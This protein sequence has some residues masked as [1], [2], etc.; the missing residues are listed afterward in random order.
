[1]SKTLF[2]YILK[3]ITQINGN[4]KKNKA[5]VFADAKPGIL[6]KLVTKM[7]RQSYSSGEYIIK[8]GDKA[9]DMFFLARGAVDIISEVQTNYMNFKS[10][11]LI[12]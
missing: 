3:K 6:N 7:S 9:T 11:I 12:K 4:V 5:A 8:C 1:L 2:L 10:Y